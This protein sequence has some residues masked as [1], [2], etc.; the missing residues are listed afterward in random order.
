MSHTSSKG[1]Y[2]L[3]FHTPAWVSDAVFYQ[4][5]P[6]R[7][8][9]S[10]RV[11]KPG[12][13]E[14]WDAPP[15]SHGFKGGDLLGVLEHLDYLQ[16]LGA[17][18]VYFTPV[19]QST[20]NHRY[21]THD[22]Y[23]VDPILGGNA[24]LRALLDEA[25]RRGMRVVLDG[26]FNH[27]SRGF[28]QFNHIL[29][30][31]K[32]SPYLDW[33][34][35]RS[36]PLFA[37]EPENAPPGYAAWW[38]LKAL[39]KFN[40]ATP[41]VHQFILDVARYWIDFGVDGWRLDV[42]GE[43]DDDE[44]WREFRRIVKS[45]NPEAYIVGEVWKP[46]ERWLQGDQFDAVMNYQFTRACIEF[47]IGR[48]ADPSF[49]PTGYGPTQAGD[50][51]QFARS[52]E[53]LLNRY[54]APATAAMLNLLDSHDMPRFLTIARGDDSALRLATLFQTTY[55][56]A[57]SIFYGD[58]IGITG[59]HDPDTRKGMIWERS[60]WN[61]DLLDYFKRCIALRRSSPALRHG[62]YQTLHAQSY[63]YVFGRQS[64]DETMV[65]ALNTARESLTLTLPL[66]DYLPDGTVLRDV[67][68]S[69]TTTITGGICELRLPPRAGVVM[70]ALA[71]RWRN[72]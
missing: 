24:A 61:T 48:D 58:E 49:I 5:F 7:F 53:T 13:L 20:A 15:T 69:T 57:P 59:G 67:W 50:A 1:R 25:H 19:F 43:I 52:I 40:T 11:A 70:E 9:I 12:N 51:T 39:P 31:G 35:V 54:P 45:A 33:F 14:P 6:D 60:R 8:A 22:Y 17:T 30:N 37:Y 71:E 4:V 36:W 68:N 23:H 41:A 44:F 18:A 65:I 28:F 29:E 34:T 3:P 27:A 10:E 16:D 21:H 63:V 47:F 62:T 72:A 26:V 38:E 64:G 2:L 46:A 42:P 32:Q 55:P 56:G 66:K